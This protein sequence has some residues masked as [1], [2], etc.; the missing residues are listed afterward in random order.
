MSFFD[1]F[2]NSSFMSCIQRLESD[3][4]C[5]GLDMRSFL[6]LPMQRITRYPL[7]VIAILERTPQ[8]SQQNKNA[9]SALHLANKVNFAHSFLILIVTKKK[10]FILINL[11]GNGL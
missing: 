9:H 8:D 1:R 3:R 5:Q 6:M 11:G 4:L 10:I 2:E 7:L